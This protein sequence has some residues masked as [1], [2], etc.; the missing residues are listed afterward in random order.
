MTKT[1]QFAVEF[2][3]FCEN[4]KVPAYNVAELI[5]LS[6]KAFS[7]GERYANSGSEKDSKREQK[8]GVAVEKF[9]LD[10]FGWETTWPG[11]WPSFSVNGNE[12]R[13]PCLPN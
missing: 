6:H 10:S 4:N 9:A 2:A 7:A 5:E 1:L 11:L 3:R 13:L 8:M 12:I